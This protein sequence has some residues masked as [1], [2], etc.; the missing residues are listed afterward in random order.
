MFALFGTPK[1]IEGRA[2]SKSF[3]TSIEKEITIDLADK[4]LQ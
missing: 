3:I 4:K 1:F 2:F